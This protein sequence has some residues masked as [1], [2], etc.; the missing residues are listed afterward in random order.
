M[1]RQT[2]TTGLF[3]VENGDFVRIMFTSFEPV[4]RQATVQTYSA[5]VGGGP[6]T[7]VAALTGTVTIP[8]PETAVLEAQNTAGAKNYEVDF[9]FDPDDLK[10]SVAV[11]DA[12]GEVDLFIG[13]RQI[14]PV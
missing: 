1:P 6:R 9:R 7:T 10:A 3:P 14:T 12:S 11:L 13:P 2:L 8:T 5:P 4:P